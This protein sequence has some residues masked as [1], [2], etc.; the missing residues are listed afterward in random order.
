M[1]AEEHHATVV[2][3]ALDVRVHVPGAERVVSRAPDAVLVLD[4]QG[5][6]RRFGEYVYTTDPGAHWHLPFPIESVIRPKVTEYKRIEVGFRTI[7]AGPPAR[8]KSFPEEALMLTGDENIVDI[9]FSV[10]WLIN[11][12]ENFLFNM[13]DPAGSVKAVAESSDRKSTRL[14]SSHSSVSRM[15]SSA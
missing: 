5:V 10:F 12:A 4:E 11:N 15:P 2:A 8:Y 3:A 6:V 7:D 13:Q 1:I 9:D 14:N